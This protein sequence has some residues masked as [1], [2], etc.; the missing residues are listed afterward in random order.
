MK[1]VEKKEKFPTCFGD[2]GCGE[3]FEYDGIYW[4][5]VYH[6]LKNEYCAVCMADGE[7]CSEFEL[8]DM[9]R[10]VKAELHILD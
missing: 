10:V 9:C 8:A 2:I 3:I 5:K 1:I 7:I 6:D 4:M